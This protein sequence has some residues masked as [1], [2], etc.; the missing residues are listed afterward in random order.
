MATEPIPIYWDSCVYI[1]C[2]EGTPGRVVVLR[3]ILRLA[4]NRSIVF[5]ASALVIAEVA[6]LKNSTD[7]IGEQARKI[8]EFFENDYIAVRGVDRKTAELAAEI[9]RDTGLSGP[10]CVHIATAIRCKCRSLQTYDGETGG[11]KKMLAFN[12]KIGTPPLTIEI[13]QVPQ[14]FTQGTLFS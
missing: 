12:G 14:Q 10:D 7:Q 13:P 2:I 1:S 4:E 9:G 3:E 11:A 6:R 5:V 8:R